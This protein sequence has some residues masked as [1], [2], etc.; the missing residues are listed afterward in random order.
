VR[1]LVTGKG[2]ATGSW[3]IRGEQ[4]GHAIGATIAPCAGP[5]QMDRADVIV[6]VKR[7][8]PELLQN[9]RGRRWVLDFVDGWP[10]PYGNEWGKREAIDWL[11]GR[12]K[13]LAPTAVVFPTTQ[14]R[15]DSGWAGPAL[16][17][18]HHA[19]PKYQRQPVAD[20]V[21][22]V[23]YEG[24]PAYLGRWR[25]VIERS[26]A[27]RG[28]QFVVNGDL[29]TCQ[30]GV[31]LRDVTGYPAGAWKA[32]TKLANL[33]ALGLPALISPEEGYREFGSAAQTEIV[34]PEH[35][36]PALDALA[37]DGIRRRL[38]DIAF[39]ATPQ[40]QHVAEVYRSWLWKVANT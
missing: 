29:S 15:K 39:A 17:L 18:P 4:L 12:L 26:C 40:L 16:V 22:R 37:G 10:Q 11:R 1:V 36:G 21:R 8:S 19:W 6:A 35:V 7:V 34:Y 13:A 33:Q 23:G 20:K 2:G 32:N 28:W 9:L 38:G 27:A 25:E 30:I 31:A 14:M 5:R 3:Q 24:A